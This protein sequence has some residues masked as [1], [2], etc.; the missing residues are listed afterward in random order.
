LT[1]SWVFPVGFTLIYSMN[2]QIVGRSGDETL[3]QWV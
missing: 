3:D 1:S 2:H